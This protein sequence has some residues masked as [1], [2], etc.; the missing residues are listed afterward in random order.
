MRPFYPA[1]VLR[2][3]W[4]R[5]I[6]LLVAA[7]WVA[8]AV[9]RG[10]SLDGSWFV[11]SALAFTG[12]AALTGWVPVVVALVLRA[13]TALLGAVLAWLVLAVAV[14]GRALDDA[15]PDAGGTRVTVMT[16]NLHFGEADPEAVVRLVRRE[17][18]DVLGAV[19][20]TPGLR[21]RLDRA[22]L[23]ELLPSRLDR[24]ARRA[25]GAVLFSRAPIGELPTV[26]AGP[27]ESFAPFGRTASLDVKVVHPFPPVNGPD[28]RVWERTLEN[29]PAPGGTRVLLGDFNATLDH[30]AFRDLLDRGWRD[31]GDVTGEGWRPTWRGGF[32]LPLTLDHVLV[33]GGVRV[34]RFSVHELEGSDHRA[35][36]ATLRLP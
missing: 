5:L 11:V 30:R 32:A 19:E 31:A 7:P 26:V 23:A 25:S 6:A 22:G 15:Q 12:W 3:S 35:V 29:L 10:L 27:R 14:H 13:R 28:H 20:L 4:R 34:E 9:A 16:A 17:R 1:S 33:S 18:V 36:V 2:V 21:G 8:F 24:S